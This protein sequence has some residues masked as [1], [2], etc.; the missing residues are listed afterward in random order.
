MLRDGSIVS[1]SSI[2]KHIKRYAEK[3]SLFIGFYKVQNERKV[4]VNLCKK[5]DAAR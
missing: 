3:K 5:S 1:F 2:V 4:S